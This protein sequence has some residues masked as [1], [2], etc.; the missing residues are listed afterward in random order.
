MMKMNPH[1][2]QSFPHLVE[3][4]DCSDD[5]DSYITFLSVLLLFL[6][7][8]KNFNN[9]TWLGSCPTREQVY[10]LKYVMAFKWFHS[11]SI[12]KFL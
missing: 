2:Q 7:S 6:N 3:G 5:D 10:G 11:P 1:F 9:L 8:N 12:C 4:I